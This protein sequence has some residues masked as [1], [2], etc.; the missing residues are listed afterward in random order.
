LHNFET[1]VVAQQWA[2]ALWA[3]GIDCTVR[4]A[5]DATFGIWVRDD[6]QMERARSVYS[7]LQGADPAALQDLARVGRQRREQEQSARAARRPRI[8]DVRARFAQRRSIGPL[9]LVLIVL[10]V[11]VGVVTALGGNMSTLHYFT[12]SDFATSGGELLVEPGFASI[13]RGQVWR[14]VSP[15]FVHFGVLHLVFNLWW[16][17]D[18]G[19]AVER[20]FSS[21]YLLVLVLVFGLTSNVAQYWWVGSPMF[22]GMSGVL[23]GLFGF[24]WLRGRLDP[25]CPVSLPNGTTLILLLWYVACL[26]GVIPNVANA[27]HTDGLLLGAAWGYLSIFARKGA[28]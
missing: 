25:S 13:E 8:I 3:Q 12:I 27:A 11:A 7:D 1:E 23:Y 4:P 15:I 5:S 20:V 18:F 26:V 6:A 28:R 17:K 16:L 10:C 21:T 9:T 24:L 14:L 2:D 19:S 22:G